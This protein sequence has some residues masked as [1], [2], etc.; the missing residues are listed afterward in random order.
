MRRLL[1][2]AWRLS[3]AERGDA[4]RAVGWLLVAAAALR[5]CSYTTVRRMLD[6]V[7]AR[8]RVRRRMTPA[9]AGTAVRRASRLLP[10]AECLDRAIAA[11]AM[12]RREGLPSTLTIEV[13]LDSGRRLHAH[14]SLDASGVTVTGADAMIDGSVIH[15]DRIAPPA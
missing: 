8:R 6:R 1:R 12:L 9:D 10:A 15:R 7:P 13:A 5:I 3:S 2:S 4:A 11:A 14:A